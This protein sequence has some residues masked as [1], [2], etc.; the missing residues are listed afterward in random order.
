MLDL[1]IKNGTLV[2]PGAGLVKGNIGVHSGKIVAV[3]ADAVNLSAREEIDASGQHVFPGVIEPHSHIGIGAGE[4]DLLTETRAAVVG[5]VTTSLFFLREPEPYDAVFESVRKAA[6]TLCLTDFGFHIVLL[7]DEHLNAIPK[8][9][10]EWGI[11]SYK[12]YMTYRDGASTTGFGGRPFKCPELTDGFMFEA[13]RRLARYPDAVAIAHCENI[14]IINRLTARLKAENRD[15]MEAWRES[16]P[17]FAEAEA[18][19]RMAFLARH[20]GARLNILHLT[21]AAALEAA[22]EAKKASDRVTVEVCHPYLAVDAASAPGVEAK[23]RPPIREREDV[24]A[25]WKGVSDGSIDSIG[26]DH[27]PRKLEAKRGSVWKPAAGGPGSPFLLQVMLT[28]GHFRRGISLQRIAEITSYNTARLYGLYPRKG[29]IRPGADA[30]L[31]V[32]DLNKE[33][34]LTVEGTDMFSDYILY[35]GRRVRGVPTVTLVRGKVVMRDGRAIEGSLRAEYL[36]RV[37]SGT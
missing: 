33:A 10:R 19:R 23:L 21:S 35:E 3:T 25:L 37:G 1:A 13:L 22:R 34:T 4:A 17:P 14:E 18:V 8:Y 36:Y 12:L 30:D 20:A 15:D 32:V 26:S 11:N 9:V 2:V 27:V 16:R 5:G 7:T 6:E 24:E 31:V 29:D 28:E